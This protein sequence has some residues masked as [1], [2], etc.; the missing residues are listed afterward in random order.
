MA[1]FV[2]IQSSEMINLIANNNM[3][4]RKKILGDLAFASI[5]F[6]TKSTKRKSAAV[7]AN[8]RFN[9]ISTISILPSPTSSTLERDF[10]I[11]TD[12]KNRSKMN[13]ILISKS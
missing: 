9:S 12:G 1:I 6:N 4:I 11:F 13:Q 2:G 5:S 10:A 3:K 7:N 8:D